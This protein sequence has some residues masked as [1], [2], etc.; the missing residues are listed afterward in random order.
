MD[1]GGSPL[2]EPP[3]E[4]EGRATK[5]AKTTAKTTGMTLEEYEAMLDAEAE[6]ENGPGGFME[7]GDIIAK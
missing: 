2:S 3:E 6:A 5:K 7:G 1:G 4:G